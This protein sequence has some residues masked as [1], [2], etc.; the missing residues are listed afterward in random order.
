MLLGVLQQF[1]GAAE[2]AGDVGAHG[3]HVAPHRFGVEHVVEAGRPPH[4]GGGQAYQLPGVGHAI[5]RQV[6]VLLLQQVQDG[7]ERAAPLWV[8]RDELPCPL[9]VFGS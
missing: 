2:H 8:Q 3:E 9:L 1:V 7:D 4:L 5:G 6:A